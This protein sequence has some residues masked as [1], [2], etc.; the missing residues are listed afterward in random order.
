MSKYT[1]AQSRAIKTCYNS[2]LK[3]GKAA[4]HLSTLKCFSGVRVTYQAVR[5]AFNKLNRNEF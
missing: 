3:P 2:G 4:N 1:K 5:V